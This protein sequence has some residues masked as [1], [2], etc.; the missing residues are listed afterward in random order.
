[1]IRVDSQ[2]ELDE[3]PCPCCGQHLLKMSNVRYSYP[4]LFTIHCEGCDYKEESEGKPPKI[5]SAEE[6]IKKRP[7]MYLGHENPEW[8]KLAEEEIERRKV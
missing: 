1:M 7:E 2:E 5:L 4:K 8:N 3:Y 6:H